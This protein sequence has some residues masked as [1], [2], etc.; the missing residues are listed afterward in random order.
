MLLTCSNASPRVPNRLLLNL[1][2][3]GFIQRYNPG[4]SSYQ[5]SRTAL[6]FVT[7]NS[8]FQLQPQL[9]LQAVF[10]LTTL[11]ALLTPSWGGW[12]R[13][14]ASPRES[15]RLRGSWLQQDRDLVSEVRSSRQHLT[16]C[17]SQAMPASHLECF[18][19]STPSL[20]SKSRRPASAS[21][22]MCSIT[23][24]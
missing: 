14:R 15:D 1:C 18:F 5:M 8:A 21:R 23:W 19:G 6:A 3:Q 24:L 9:E 4:S 7:K 10:Q 22:L 2:V 20:G 12:R 17:K 16:A 11:R 13:S